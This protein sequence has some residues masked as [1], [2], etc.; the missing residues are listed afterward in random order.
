MTGAELITMYKGESDGLD[1][2]YGIVN[3]DAVILTE[4]NAE[5]RKVLSGYTWTF[6]KKLYN[7]PVVPDPEGVVYTVDRPTGDTEWNIHKIRTVSTRVYG[8]QSVLLQKIDIAQIHDIGKLLS[9]AIDHENDRIIISNIFP[10]PGNIQI[11][12]QKLASSLTPTTS[13]IFHEDFHQVLVYGALIRQDTIAKT[14]GTR[15]KEAAWTRAYNAL[16]TS[17]KRHYTT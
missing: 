16:L 3:N 15:N 4:I 1:G 7:L 6:L 11:V 5:Y 8:A 9:Y 17:M 12:M 13:P 10:A 2:G 14:E